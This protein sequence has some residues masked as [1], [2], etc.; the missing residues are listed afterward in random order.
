MQV[1][2]ER[3]GANGDGRGTCFGLALLNRL[4]MKSLQGK[5]KQNVT[6]AT[7]LLAYFLGLPAC[8]DLMP[9]LE[10]AWIASLPILGIGM[11]VAVSPRTLLDPTIK[12]GHQHIG[13]LGVTPCLG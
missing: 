6:D 13:R 2:T 10:T 11:C 8:F 3:V 12:I 4:A 1:M 9:D 7:V 5:S